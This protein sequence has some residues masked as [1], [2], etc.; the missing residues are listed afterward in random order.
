MA[1][2]QLTID[3]VDRGEV[4]DRVPTR[5]VLSWAS[6]GFG[7]YPA[8]AEFALLDIDFDTYRDTN[9][10]IHELESP[11][12]LRTKEETYIIHVFGTDWNDIIT[13]L[14]D[15]L[16]R[17]D[18]DCEILYIDGLQAIGEDLV[19]VRNRLEE[20]R[21]V[22]PSDVRIGLIDA[23]PGGS[24]VWAFAVGSDEFDA[25]LQSLH[26][27]DEAALYGQR[28]AE[29]RDINRW[30]RVDYSGGRPG[31]GFTVEDG[32]LIPGEDYEEVC[33][34]LELVREGKMS[35]RKAAAH[36]DTSPRTI[37]RCIV[38]RPDRYGL[39]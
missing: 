2:T 14:W 16:E 4:S 34:V 5:I 10:T 29:K 32:E 31:L 22:L 23:D 11:A 36:L 13:D 38:E 3:D 7:L 28:A 24:D 12:K 39:S 1:T 37:T 35:K 6:H 18:T 21:N 15:V 8:S 20:L 27:A 9:D 30:A 26:F 33:A 25:L 17:P 19:T